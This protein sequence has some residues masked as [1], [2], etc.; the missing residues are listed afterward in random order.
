MEK[1]KRRTRFSYLGELGF[2]KPSLLLLLLARP[3]S[4]SKHLFSLLAF[5]FSL[6]L[7]LFSFLSLSLW[8]FSQI[9]AKEN[10]K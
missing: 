10:Q 2:S 1:A 6:K 8:F 9:L 4:N 3:L 5:S 7:S